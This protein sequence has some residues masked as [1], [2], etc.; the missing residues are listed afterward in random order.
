MTTA[1]VSRTE[2]SVELVVPPPPTPP[3]VDAGRTAATT[4]PPKDASGTRWPS[5][6]QAGEVM[7]SPVES[8]DASASMWE[9]ARRLFG[10][11]DAHLVVMD[12]SRPVGVVNE[13]VVALQWPGGP[14]DAFRRE[15]QD[16]TPRGVRTVLP[17]AHVGTVAEIMLK[18]GVEA[19]PV[20]TPRGVVVG[21]VTARN[22]LEL[23]AGCPSPT[24]W[25]D[26]DEEA[27]VA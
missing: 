10:D 11:G 26:Q 6:I 8:I 19:V 13:A 12:G 21:L 23:L 15:I 22:L 20:V 27:A 14:I 24:P 1:T 17:G 18:D 9:A 5:R 2:A 16:L 7:S 4:V 25:P 3:T